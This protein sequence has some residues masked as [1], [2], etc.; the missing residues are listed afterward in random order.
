MPENPL[1]ITLV[2]QGVWA[3]ETASMPLASGYI[4]A[5]L[6]Q[7]PELSLCRTTIANFGG[8]AKAQSVIREILEPDRPDI[9][10]FSVF[11]WNY[12]LFG[13]VSETLKQVSPDILVVFGGPHVSNQGDQVF[14]KYPSV[15]VVVNGEGEYIFRD[16]VR[17]RLA[18]AVRS[19]LG[20]VN[21]IA[22]QRDGVVHV[23]P[24]RDRISN[25]DDIPSPILRGALPLTDPNG[26]FLYDVAIMETNRG[27]P[28]KCAFCYWGGAVG[29]RVRAFSRE[30]LRA[31]LE[32]FARLNV[33]TIVLCDANFGMLRADVDFI[34][35]ILDLKATYG[36]PKA[37][38]T[39]WAK[40]KSATFRS[41]VEKMHFGELHSSFT[42][43]LQSLDEA[44]LVSMNRRNMAVNDWEELVDWLESLGLDC[45]GELI[46][47]VPGE[48]SEGF[49]KGYDKLAMRMSRI[50]VYPLLIMP[51]TDYYN[52]KQE[53]GLITC[54]GK[55]DDFQ[56]VLGS[57]S[58]PMDE[59]ARVSSFVLWARLLGESSIF[60]NIWRPLHLLASRSQSDV[61]NS[62][63]TWA[64]TRQTGIEARLAA[65]AQDYDAPAALAEALVIFYEQSAG[66]S[67]LERWWDAE[68]RPTLPERSRVLLSE[69]FYF[70]LETLPRYDLAE[71]FQLESRVGKDNSNYC[72]TVEFKYP[73]DVLQQAFWR[74]WEADDSVN[75]PRPCL[76][77]AVLSYRSGFQRYMFNHEEAIAF[78][79]RVV[80]NPKATDQ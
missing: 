64:Q 52:S 80:G 47:G 44:A 75:V 22:F 77:S 63:R 18:D 32:V 46:Y 12:D 66:R 17:A 10:G 3:Q 79:G 36:Y 21:G 78:F 62:V 70:D 9:V 65:L 31:E 38:E 68:L 43:A 37:L 74:R 4:K 5:V 69:I 14:R 54:R 42:I 19:D 71:D 67:M 11:G 40:N 51:N 73:V 61:I 2:Q 1:L 50:A 29:Q 59:A 27:C 53:H 13:R 55:F 48:T 30:R 39:S 15:D 76:T 26:E 23:T 24:D 34:D 20:R 57:N 72:R 58:L 45:Y 33:E 41:I 60:R 16:I 56:Y 35:D 49:F 6:D 7:D 28:Y 25:L 8:A